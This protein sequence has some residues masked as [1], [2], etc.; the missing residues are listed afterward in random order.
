MRPVDYQ[1]VRLRRAELA[2]RADVPV[3]P[4]WGSRIIESVPL[5]TLVTYLNDTMLYQFQWGY[6][7]AGRTLDEWR[8]WAAKELRPLAVDLLKRC[9]KEGILQP[10]AA[11]G[12]WK[13]ASLGDRIVLFAEDGRTEVARFSFPRQAGEGGLCI[14]DFVREIDAPERDVIGLQVVT[15]GSQASEVARHWFAENRYKDYL[16][17]HGLS[18]EMAEALAEYVHAR[19]RSELGFGGEDDRDIDKMLRQNYRGSRY[20][21]GYPACPNLEDQSQ[22]LALLKAER[23]GVTLTEEWQL[24]PEQS[25]SAIVLLHPQAKY[26]S[27]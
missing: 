6:K 16:H 25:T 10:K 1:E 20:S 21:F 17:L 8:V 12:Y 15:M 7:K 2:G 9:Q 14:A 19:I 4:F 22:L 24:E 27:V 13:C 3:P 23:I 18:V 11:Y 26:F 5:Q